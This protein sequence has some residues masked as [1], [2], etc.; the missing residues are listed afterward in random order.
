[1]TA[2][3]LPVVYPLGEQLSMS[4]RKLCPEAGELTL[5]EEVGKGIVSRGYTH[6]M[7]G[8]V[9]CETEPIDLTKEALGER[10]P[11]MPRAKAMLNILI[12]NMDHHCHWLDPM[13]QETAESF[14]NCQSLQKLYVLATVAMRHITREDGRWC[15]GQTQVGTIATG[16]CI[17]PNMGNKEGGRCQDGGARP[18]A[19]DGRPPAELSESRAGDPSVR[20]EPMGVTSAI[21]EAMEKSLATRENLGYKVE[22]ARDSLHV[23]EVSCAML[24]ELVALGEEVLLSVLSNANSLSNRVNFNTED[25]E[26]SEACKSLPGRQVEAQSSGC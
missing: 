23:K 1:M 5:G 12:V 20:E 26:T 21:I 14:N 9:T 3:W 2:G 19:E 17:C 16:A 18:G 8:D 25:L 10:V 15:I 22:K 6:Q 13:V 4:M 24:E 7:Q 11:R